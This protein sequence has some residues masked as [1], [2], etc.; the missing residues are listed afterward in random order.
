MILDNIKSYYSSQY[1][2][3]SS[4]SESDC[5]SYLTNLNLS[6][7]SED[8]QTLCEGKLT[9]RECWEALLSMGSNKSPGND[10]LSKEF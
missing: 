5:P 6:K 3:R 4:K 8:Q 1:K 2:R 10:G 9:R 7:L